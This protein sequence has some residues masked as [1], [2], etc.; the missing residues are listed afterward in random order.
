MV[1]QRAGNSGY[2][3]RQE[4]LHN[5]WEYSDCVPTVIAYRGSL[6][7]SSGLLIGFDVDSHK[8]LWSQTSEGADVFLSPEYRD[9]LATSGSFSELCH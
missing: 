2:K 7:T 9:A 1:S 5:K 4:L 3:A 6:D 8:K